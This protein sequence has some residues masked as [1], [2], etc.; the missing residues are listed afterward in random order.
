MTNLGDVWT[1]LRIDTSKAEAE[2]KA[3]EQKAERSKTRRKQAEGEPVREIQKRPSPS[4]DPEERKSP[5]LRPKKFSRKDMTDQEAA[6]LE[7]LRKRRRSLEAATAKA[8]KTFGTRKGA[9]GRIAQTARATVGRATGVAAAI[10]LG[11]RTVATAG[12]AVG[13]FGTG[14]GI[15]GAESVTNELR[16]LRTKFQQFESEIASLW[17]AIPKTVDFLKVQ[18]R[19][20]G[21]IPAGAFGFY[22]QQFQRMDSDESSL[23]KRFESFKSDS[24]IRAFGD[25]FGKMV[26]QSLSQ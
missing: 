19:V 2:L 9:A 13:E 8:Q 23:K 18:G 25:G 6:Q 4:G 21:T 22:Y 14:L 11:T 12:T 15:P 16:F 5:A 7:R 20:T 17:N 3:L 24:V 1:E 26:S 10:Y